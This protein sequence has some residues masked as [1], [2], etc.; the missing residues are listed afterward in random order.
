MSDIRCPMCSKPNPAELEVCIYCQARLKPLII[1]PPEE[2]RPPLPAKPVNLPSESVTHSTIREIE[3][4]LPDWLSDFREDAPGTKSLEGPIQ[5]EEYPAEAEEWLSRL[6]TEA[7]ADNVP[8][9]VEPQIPLSTE[10]PTPTSAEPVGRKSDHPFTDWLTNLAVEAEPSP[11]E[12]TQPVIELPDWLTN[13]TEP[14][15][16]SETEK[17]LPAWLTEEL[18]KIETSPA[19]SSDV[20][21]WL[22]GLSTS[23]SENLRA[24]GSLEIEKSPLFEEIPDWLSELSESQ[25]ASLGL[26]GPADV[27]PF[28]ESTQPSADL[29][30]MAGVPLV[31]PSAFVLA[32]ETAIP[33]KAD[34]A[35]KID[36]DK[37]PEWFRQV[38]RE[39][40]EH[41]VPIITEPEEKPTG[42]PGWLE[43]MRPVESAAPAINYFDDTYERQEGTGPLA[44]IQGVLEVGSGIPG[45]NK[46]TPYSATL[47]ATE[48]QQKNAGVLKLLFENEGETRPIIQRSLV[49]KQ[50]IWRILI[51]FLLIIAVLWP[52]INNSRSSPLPDITPETAEVNRIISGLSAKAPVLLAFDYQPG[53]MGEMDA[54][55][56]A[57]VDRLM[58]RGVLL[59]IVSTSPVGPILAEQ[60]IRDVQQSHHYTSPDQYVNLGYIPGGPAG[61][62]SFAQSPQHSLPM[63]L[64]GTKAWERDGNPALSPLQGVSSLADFSLV[65]VIVDDP[66]TARAW[67]EQA[68]PYLNQSP[69]VMVISAQAEPLVRPYYQTYPRQIQGLIIGLRG[70]AAFASLTG[71][72][73]QSR[74]YWDAFSAGLIAAVLL[75]GVGGLT[76]MMISI[77]VGRRRK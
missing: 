37:M 71:R 14:P 44:G 11:S 30:D 32:G 68:Q 12:P 4:P 52:I 21:D 65:M 58:L 34:E 70:G 45:I 55:A 39:E 26:S 8:G 9:E 38:T 66:D 75:I 17:P 27:E 25:I 54:A 67:V 36:I 60:F 49:T 50:Y 76:N 47:Q 46:P 7:N 57:V 69:L 5:S 3:P 77:Q 19:S 64:E 6:Q 53:F 61:L 56:A 63:T 31:K 62:L 1:R 59:T 72:E 42:L 10:K 33:G 13:R 22:A 28:I 41:H 23:P 43:A 24:D 73:G 40:I 20:P 29:S 16:T 74:D 48:N 2:D 18:D 51:A 15:P 35:E